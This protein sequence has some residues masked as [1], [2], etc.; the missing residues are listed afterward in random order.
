MV[1]AA[2][3]LDD[4]DKPKP[5]EQLQALQKEFR[6]ELNRYQL[7]QRNGKQDE[8]KQA[9]EKTE[10]AAGQI[11]ELARNNPKEPAAVGALATL[12]SAS[13]LAPG[14]AK[15]GEQAAGLILEFART[16]PKEP[17]AAS[18]L[19][20]LVSTSQLAPGLAKFG[21][22]AIDALLKDHLGSPQIGTLCTI[23]ARN[24]SLAAEKALR[25]IGEKSPDRNVQGLACYNLGKHLAE[26]AEKARIAKKHQEADS[27]TKE[28]E[29]ALEQVAA[30]YADVKYGRT[31]TLGDAVKGELYEMKHLGVG[32]T[33][34]EIDG[35]DIDG[36]KFKLSD[37]RGK[38]ILL[39]FWGHW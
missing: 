9:L 28:A 16:N 3:A 27:L 34:P 17:A 7:A 30:K 39:D 38:V 36:Q 11:L 35:E 13:R 18:A 1:P 20:S 32:M 4:K 8:A 22:P 10:K 31:S 14:L 5:A 29:K 25:I 37:Y 19:V 26:R 12:V 24:E 21:G 33:V 23:L 15:A 2:G 6:T